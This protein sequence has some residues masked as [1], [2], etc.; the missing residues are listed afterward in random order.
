M[1]EGEMEE[2]M[3]GQSGQWSSGTNSMRPA[4][5]DLVGS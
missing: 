3:E 2:R 4:G 1:G 5:S